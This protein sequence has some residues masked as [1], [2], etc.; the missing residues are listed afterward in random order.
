[1]TRVLV[2]FL[3]LAAA[4][5]AQSPP[6]PTFRTDTRTVFVDV[7]V[8]KGN[9]PVRGLRSTDFTLHDN[10]IPQQIDALAIGDVPIDVSLVIDASGSTAQA[11][12]EMTRSLA[13]IAAMLR[14]D[15]RFRVLA[16]GHSVYQVVDW[17]KAGQPT[18]E[19]EMW[20]ISGISLVY[21]AV[22]AAARHAVA[23]G[24]RHLLVALT[25]GED[26]CSIVKPSDLKD[27]AGRTETAVHWVPMRGANV[28][29]GGRAICSGGVPADPRVLGALVDETGGTVHSGLLG[30]GIGNSPVKAFKR[31]LDD[32]RQSYVLRYVPRDVTGPGWHRLVVQV[33]SGRYT[34]RARAGYFG[35]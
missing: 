34:I 13:E 8:K 24:R 4:P 31:V 2:P 5:V 33:P 12:G 10:G 1:M 15:D 25:D 19:I 16:I 21:D 11:L 6:Q 30:S 18:G 27:L 9:T 22:Y 3:V 14:V 20:P 17:T 26:H 7:S 29:R 35:R 32:Y 28:F 23:P